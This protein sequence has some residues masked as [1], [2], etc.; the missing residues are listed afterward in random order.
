MTSVRPYLIRA[1]IDW[2]VDNDHTPYVAID[3]RV[4]GVQ[5]PVDRAKE[6]KL[7]VNVS[8]NATRHLDIDN[9]WLNVDCRFGGRPFHVAAPLGAVV[10]VYSR[11]SNMGMAFEAEAAD[12]EAA[13][14]EAAQTEPPTPRPSGPNLTLVK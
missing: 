9:E 12:A 10:A 1:L 5:A 6:G 3:C 8:A 7:V 13:D 4:A 14:A 11:E 2:I